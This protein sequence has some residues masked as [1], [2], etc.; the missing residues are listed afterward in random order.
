MK[1]QLI[2]IFAFVSTIMFAQKVDNEKGDLSSL[3]GQTEI[4]VEFDYSSLKLMKENITEAEY[5]KKRSEELNT[6]S[7]GNG[8]VWSKK[9]FASK[10]LIWNPKFIELLNVVSKKEKT[11]LVFGENKTSAKYTV[12]VIVDWIYP[13]WDVAMM[14]QPAKVST[15][16]KVVETANKSKVVYQAEFI[17]APGDQ[18]G[19]NFSNESRIGEGFAKTGKT[20]AKLITK[21]F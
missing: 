15:T 14:K 3:K 8:D 9:W 6:K 12:L 5:V 18:W 4:N 7:P 2:A 1:K 20:L 13:G 11:N 19:N 16:V 10:E 21:S 17:H